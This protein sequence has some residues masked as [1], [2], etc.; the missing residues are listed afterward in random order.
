MKHYLIGVSKRKFVKFIFFTVKGSV[1]GYERSALPK[2]PNESAYSATGQG[3]IK[4]TALCS[5]PVIIMF[6]I[7]IKNI[8]T[9]AFFLIKLI[10]LIEYIREVAVPPR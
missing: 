2:C 1:Q 4:V 7:M 10:S 9:V 5:K 6:M 8:L 3:D